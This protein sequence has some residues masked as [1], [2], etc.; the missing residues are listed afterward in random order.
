MIKRTQFN[1][2]VLEFEQNHFFKALRNKFS[3]SF[4][5]TQILF[6]INFLVSILIFSINVNYQKHL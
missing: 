6:S 4:I 2:N 1:S 3:F 5:L